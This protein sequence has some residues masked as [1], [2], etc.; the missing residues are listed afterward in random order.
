MKP[1][2]HPGPKDYER[3]QLLYFYLNK[4]KK[5]IKRPPSC[6]ICYSWGF[7]D[8]EK[9][10]QNEASEKYNKAHQARVLKLRNRLIAAGIHALIDVKDCV[11]TPDRFRERIKAIGFKTI[12]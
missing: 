11:S 12:L 4:I 3:D 2:I 5:L 6:F 10:Y 1:S 9:K 8:Q 7:P